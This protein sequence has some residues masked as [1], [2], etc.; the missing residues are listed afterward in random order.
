MNQ[1]DLN[2]RLT[3]EEIMNYFN[4]MVNDRKLISTKKYDLEINS[5]SNYEDFDSII[6]YKN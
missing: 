1:L 6:K 2:K 5:S 4:H 3:N